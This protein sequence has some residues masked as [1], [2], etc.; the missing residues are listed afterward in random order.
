MSCEFCEKNVNIMYI[1]SFVIFVFI[2]F[3]F[4]LNLI[5]FRFFCSILLLSFIEMFIIDFLYYNIKNKGSRDGMIGRKN[6][7]RII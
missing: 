3:F 5:K 1:Y 4:V 7:K 6:G 2:I